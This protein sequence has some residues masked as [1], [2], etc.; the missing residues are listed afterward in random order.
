MEQ[1]QL[2]LTLDRGYYPNKEAW[3][4]DLIIEG[5]PLPHLV[6]EHIGQRVWAV[7][8]RKMVIQPG[9][10]HNPLYYYRKLK[11]LK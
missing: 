11:G 7:L 10:L 1:I 2:T 4:S 6:R 8:I 9:E 3:W 5:Y